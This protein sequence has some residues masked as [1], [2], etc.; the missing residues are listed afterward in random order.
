M[1]FKEIFIKGSLIAFS[2]LILLILIEGFF[3]IYYS[4]NY[5]EQKKKFYNLIDNKISNSEL[6]SQDPYNNEDKSIGRTLENR[7]THSTNGRWAPNTLARNYTYEYLKEGKGDG[8]YTD[9]YGF[10]H[11]GN[12]D[13][14][15]FQ[16]D[17]TNIIIIGGSTTEGA[18]STSSND[19][20]IAAHL[21]KKLRQG[22]QK[23]NIINA[24]KSGYK[25]FDEFLTIYHLLG[26]Y[27]F[28]EII[29]LNG[30]NDFL[31][32]TYSSEEKWN[33]YQEIINYRQQFSFIFDKKYQ[34]KTIYYANRIRSII[35]NKFLN[36]AKNVRN[37]NFLEN[38]FQED[39]DT[40]EPNKPDKRYVKNYIYNLRLLK[41]LCL[42]F[43]IKCKFY[44]QPHIGA[45]NIL[46]EFEKEIISRLKFKDFYET[47]SNWNSLVSLEINK[48]SE[49]ENI[50]FYDLKDIFKDNPKLIY[51]DL[52]HYNDYGNEIIA[53]NIY[54]NFLNN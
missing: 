30:F 17:Y 1:K 38:I 6:I 27:N 53:E 43:E 34:L 47:I 20:T 24:G 5:F 37:D 32:L 35:D 11:N 8:L 12:P 39:F 33:Y 15:L 50:K 19:N 26:K 13:R 28:Q 52:A 54:K 48:I 29:F 41:T 22:S 3:S 42:E 18:N 49:T 16:K 45:K 21:E 2:I 44:L 14:D 31:S 10:I 4:L 23:I 25:T 9:K 7:Y 40:Y 51:Y 36:S 46:H